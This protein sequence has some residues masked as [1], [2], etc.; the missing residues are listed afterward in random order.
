MMKVKLI[1][2][3]MAIIAFTTAYANSDSPPPPELPFEAADG[4]S[5][6]SYQNGE[7]DDL[8]AYDNSNNQVIVDP[9]F[10]QAT[11]QIT[12]PTHFQPRQ[13]VP[14]EPL[15]QDQ[16]TQ[17]P[18]EE[19][20]LAPKPK[21]RPKVLDKAPENSAEN[22][23]NSKGLDLGLQSGITIKP[24][25]GRTESVI[26]A[27]G[28][29]N[30]IVTPYAEPKVLTVDNVETKVDGSAIYIAT[31]SESPV[32]M[33]I[34]D[35]ES[36]NAASLQLSPQELVMPV[37]IRIEGDPKANTSEAGS[38]KNDRLFRQDS[39]Y[40][41]EVKSIMQNLGK[42]QIPQGFTLVDLTDELRAMTFCH[43]PGLTYWPGQ[44]LSGHDSRIVVLIA[45]NNG[46]LATTFEESFCASENTMA[47]AAWPKVRLEP[48]EKTEIYLLLR[49]PEG[50]SGEEIR[51]AL[52]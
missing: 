18:L 27:K 24:K 36:G 12:P 32:S 23:K 33:F 40:I 14:D 4:S 31:D 43:D 30:R 6:T 17:I 51:P 44:L 29:L 20:K 10:K 39:P 52:L 38:S 2:N 8:G 15:L 37:E 13:G 11:N 5:L 9:V 28:K 41:T 16:Q 50:K 3:S 7:A 34:S 47:V 46:L 25:P 49:L 21:K 26:I 22:S 45:Q 48:G 1:I 42:Q 19:P 35:S